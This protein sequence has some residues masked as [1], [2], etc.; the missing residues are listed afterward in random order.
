MSAAAYENALMAIRRDFPNAIEICV[1]DSDGFEE[2]IYS[3]K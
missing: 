3:R 1:G 2:V